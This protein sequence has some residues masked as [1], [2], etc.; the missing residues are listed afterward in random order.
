MIS[1]P[2]KE[3]DLPLGFNDPLNYLETLV[4]WA[5]KY[6]WLYDLHIVDFFTH[7]QWNK[8]DQEWTH[9]LEQ[10]ENWFDTVIQLSSFDPI[11][12]S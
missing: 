8:L 2:E 9:V 6:K 11:I 3:I 10:E 12:V 1:L 7:D 4:S 5:N